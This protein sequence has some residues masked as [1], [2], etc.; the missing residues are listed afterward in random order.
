MPS[1][2][3]NVIRGIGA[4]SGQRR[5]TYR[6]TAIV[7]PLSPCGRRCGTRGCLA[8]VSQ[9][10]ERSRTCGQRRTPAC[11]AASAARPARPSPGRPLTWCFHISGPRRVHYRH[12]ADQSTRSELRPAGR[13]RRRRVSVL[14]K[15]GAGVVDGEPPHVVRQLSQPQG[16]RGLRHR[17]RVRHR[18]GDRAR[19]R[20]AGLE[21]RLRRHRRGARRDARRR[22]W[23]ARAR[24]SVSRPATCATSTRCSAPSPPSRRS[25]GPPP[26]SSTTP[27]ATTATAGRT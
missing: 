27:R 14:V 20:R 7:A 22:D 11:R 13:R 12:L 19:L 1:Q 2:G 18:R 8:K 3:Q 17:R 16:R 5:R 21:G 25:S 10:H 23:Q 15:P 26:S 6:R 24:R 9:A 4:C